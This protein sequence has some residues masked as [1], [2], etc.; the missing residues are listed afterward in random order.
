[1]RARIAWRPRGRMGKRGR[2]CGGGIDVERETWG[3]GG[4]VCN[5]G[6]R[7]QLQSGGLEGGIPSPS[8]GRGLP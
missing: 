8:R 4:G 1:V 6:G 5:V 7:G 2:K 3:S